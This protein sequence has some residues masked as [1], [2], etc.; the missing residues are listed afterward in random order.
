MF[1]ARQLLQR[2][3]RSVPR[4]ASVSARQF[5]ASAVAMNLRIGDTA[6]DFTA[7]TSQG[8]ISF[9]DWIGDSWALFC[10]HPK[11]YTPVCTTELGMLQKLL[12]ELERRNV[13]PIA[14]SVDDVDSHAG[15]AQDISDT[16][17][18]AEITYPIVADAS[19]KISEQYGMLD[20]TNINDEGL[21]LTVRAVYVIDPNKKVRLTVVYPASTGRNF[22][23]LIR[24]IDSLQLTDHHQ[25]ATPANWQN[26]EDCVVVPSLSN[27]EAE[28]KFKKGVNVVRPYLRMTPDPRT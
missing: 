1:A 18:V 26:G 7:S 28:A 23:E 9:H 21:P 20:Q 14:L 24:V 27:E 6:P 17:G 13:K 22:N 16:Q 11:D 5:H 10:S 8:E 15:W 2:S 19:R 3:V 12:P 25:V 4:L